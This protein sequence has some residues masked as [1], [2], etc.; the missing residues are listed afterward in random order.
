[1]SPTCPTKGKLKLFDITFMQP[2]PMN[3]HFFVF[4]AIALLIKY[5]F[6]KTMNGNYMQFTFRKTICINYHKSN[7][8][9]YRLLIA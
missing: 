7:Y 6:V 5:Y 3:A 4:Y 9:Q 1:M 2:Y 8:V